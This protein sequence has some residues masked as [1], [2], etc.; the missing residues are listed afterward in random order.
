M[1]LKRLSVDTIREIERS[2]KKQPAFYGD[3]GGY[4]HVYGTTTIQPLKDMLNRAAR[5]GVDI[6]EFQA[7]SHLQAKNG[8]LFLHNIGQHMLGFYV[9]SYVY[10][11]RE[12]DFWRPVDSPMQTD[13]SLGYITTKHFGAFPCMG[14]RCDK[15]YPTIFLIGF[16]KYGKVCCNLFNKE[17]VDYLM[18]IDRH[19]TK[20][21]FAGVFNATMRYA[22]IR[23]ASYSMPRLPHSW[24]APAIYF[25][26][27]IAMLNNA[28]SLVGTY[29]QKSNDIPN[30]PD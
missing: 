19:S 10:G 25:D 7:L 8:L 2:L 9:C 29:E 24:P 6:G 20:E 13:L 26:Q 5:A 18:Y 17:D 27:E 15:P 23:D 22:K 28:R 1:I 4:S 16:K 3:F 30:M 12:G 21:H 11:N 14:Y